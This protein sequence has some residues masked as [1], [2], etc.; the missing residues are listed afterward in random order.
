MKKHLKTT[1]A[2][3]ALAVSAA[4]PAHAS[5]IGDDVGIQYFVTTYSDQFNSTVTVTDPGTEA[6]F[7]A[8]NV[9]IFASSFIFDYTAAY[10]V[11]V[12]NLI[13]TDLDAGGA[14]TNVVMTGGE[15]SNL[16][17]LTFTA[18]S[19]SIQLDNGNGTQ[20]DNRTYEF[21]I[22]T[23]AV[24]LPAGA[25]LLLGGLGLLAAFR[26]RKKKSN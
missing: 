22:S 8:G 26:M 23:T 13:L 17:S 3:A 6:S 5:L 15:A 18:N 24:P 25:P 7:S 21:A 12:S 19:I 9:D 16:L 2:A 4:L 1:V 14:I 11:N 10:D 20:N